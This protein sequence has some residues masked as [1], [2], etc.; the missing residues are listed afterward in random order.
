MQAPA[1]P[2]EATSLGSTNLLAEIDRDD[3]ET[4]KDEG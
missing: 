1:R 4:M 2:R 3:E